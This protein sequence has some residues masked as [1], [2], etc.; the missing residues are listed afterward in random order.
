MD[1][2]Q[3][4][5]PRENKELRAI[6]TA[7]LFLILGFF[8]LWLAKSIVH[9]EGDAV[10]ISLL[11]IPIL[12]YVII[13]G[14]LEELKGPGGLEAKFARAANE[15]ISTA[16]EKV[17]LSTEEMQI[18]EKESVELL[19][20]KRQELNE[21]QPIVMIMELGKVNYYQRQATLSYLEML[22]QFRNFKFVVFV[23]KSKRFVAYMP[24]WA[25][26]GLLSKQQLGDE[27]IWGI[28][29]GRIQDLFRYPGVVRE[30]IRTQSTNAEALREM[31]RQNLEALVVIDENS[32][33]KGVVEREQVLSR[34][35]LSLTK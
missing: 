13:S 22:S 15:S 26:K 17:E 31:T 5:T 11:L 29:Q 28:N 8:V 35:M 34:M 12:M 7:V 32:Q 21:A 9:V 27:F 33:L 24:S 23:D 6:G 2:L 10:F 16:S 20:R 1:R 14:K 3:Q 4:E 18:V 19:E 25:V 30:T